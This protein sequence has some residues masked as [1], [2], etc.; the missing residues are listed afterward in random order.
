MKKIVL[1]IIL[2]LASA[3]ISV[4]TSASA[5][6]PQLLLNDAVPEQYQVVAGD[7]LWDISALFLRDPW[8]WPEIWHANQQI[9]NPHLIYPGDIISLVYLDGRPRLMLSRNRDE[10][11]SPQIR[12]E[13]HKAPIPALPLETI[14]NFLSKNRVTSDAELR[15]APYVLGGYERRLLVG[16]GDDFYARGDFSSQSLNYGIYRRGNPYIDPSSGE[17][18]G[19][20][21]K[22]VGRAQVKVVKDDIATLGTTYAEGEIRVKDR[23]LNREN[24]LLPSIF[25]PR[26]PEA[27]VDA[28]VISVE[29][30]VRNAGALDVVAI[31]RG[32]RDG[33]QAGD[34]LAIFKRGELVKDQVVKRPVRLPD[35]RIGLLMVF[36]TYQKMSFGLVLVADRQ[37][38]L[39]DLARNP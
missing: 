24:H 14:E 38:D 1:G 37:L 23:L 25:H 32:D 34:T 18:L 2:M 35:E 8:M 12:A 13:D 7:T 22:S 4:Q 33:L 27:K 28:V 19:I 26:A 30:G 11:L 21:A 9:A 31:N 6:D 20:S 15:S 10:K 36:R 5:D 3:V 17:V 16:I 29:G 39:G